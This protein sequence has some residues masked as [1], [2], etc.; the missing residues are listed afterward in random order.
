MGKL[1]DWPY[2]VV[3]ESWAYFHSKMAEAK[4]CWCS[5][6]PILWPEGVHC[7]CKG[8][9]EAG[10]LGQ[11]WCCG[12]W[13]LHRINVSVWTILDD[14][15]QS[16]TPCTVQALGR[17]DCTLH[18]GNWQKEL[19]LQL[20][21][22]T[23][24]FSKIL[25]LASDWPLSKIFI[26]HLTKFQNENPNAPLK[27]SWRSFRSSEDERSIL[28]IDDLPKS[29]EVCLLHEVSTTNTETCR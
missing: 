16:W 19:N 23:A 21:V 28:T 12:H 14:P 4:S 27:G 15:F 3:K 18:C 26:V 11:R 9:F 25:C 22:P 24:Q 8:L 1:F 20:C 6:Q 29:R 17:K 13:T 7:M 10:Y 5:E 2:T